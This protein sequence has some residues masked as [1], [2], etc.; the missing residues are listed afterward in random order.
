MSIPVPLKAVGDKKEFYKSLRFRNP[1]D[2][3][4][5]QRF[6]K[7]R[8]PIPDTSID[9]FLPNPSSHCVYVPFSRGQKLL[10]DLGH[11]DVHLRIPKPKVSFDFLGEPREIQRSFLRDGFDMVREKGSVLLSAHPGFGKTFAAIHLAYRLN[12]LTLILVNRLPLVEQWRESIKAFT[13]ATAWVYGTPLPDQDYQF[14]I[15]MV[16]SVPKFLPSVI[17]RIGTLILDEAHM[18]ATPTQVPSILRIHPNYLILCTATPDRD[19]RTELILRSFTADHRVVRRYDKMLSVLWYHTDITKVPKNQRDGSPLYSDYVKQ[20]SEDGERNQL[21]MQWILR[22]PGEKIMILTPSQPHTL[23]LHA[24]LKER[25]ITSD[26][27]SGNRKSYKDGDVLVGT[28]SKIGVGF[29]P[30]ANPTWDGRHYRILIMT[31]TTKQEALIEQIWGR[32]F[33]AHCPVV[34]VFMDDSNLST[35]HMRPMKK[36]AKIYKAAIH[37]VDKPMSLEVEKM[38]QMKGNGSKT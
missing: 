31:G 12:R 32:T 24:M 16:G 34:V 28:F 20:L 5:I 3:R 25:G 23:V 37:D 19:Q 30:G 6:Q 35:N 11:P 17:K 7:Y 14:I 27:Y 15:S 18:L 38:E 8:T 2:Y 21:I 36:I 33:R 10:E 29:D 4:D 26:Y 1:P 9:C 22:N 13:N